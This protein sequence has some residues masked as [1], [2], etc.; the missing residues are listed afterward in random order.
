M[1][2]NDEIP[3]NGLEPPAIAY[4]R[5]LARPPM[6]DPWVMSEAPCFQTLRGDSAIRCF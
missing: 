3:Q 6:P 2:R 1:K 5:M 4:A